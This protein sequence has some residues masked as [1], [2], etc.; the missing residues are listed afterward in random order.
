MD[1]MLRRAKNKEWRIKNKEHLQRVTCLL[2]RL[3]KC[4]NGQNHNVRR[5]S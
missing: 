4:Q 2:K 1:E 3:L 5:F